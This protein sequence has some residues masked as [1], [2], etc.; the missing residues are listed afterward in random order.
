MKNLRSS[1]RMYGSSRML[2]VLPITMLTVA[3]K[4]GV[5]A[6]TPV[7]PKHEKL[8]GHLRFDIAKSKSD[9]HFPNIFPNLALGTPFGGNLGVMWSNLVHLGG[10]ANRASDNHAQLTGQ[11]STGGLV[12]ILCIQTHIVGAVAATAQLSTSE[13]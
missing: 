12:G 1:G 9:Q 2:T 11:A 5:S 8:E 6:E 7:F 10:E 4:P 3:Y 13:Y